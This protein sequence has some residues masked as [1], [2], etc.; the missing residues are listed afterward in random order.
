MTEQA[1]TSLNHL[2]DDARIWLYAANRELNE[3]EEN[4]VR[5]IL[6][7]FCRTWES[8]GRS[9]QSAADVLEGRFA[10]IAGCI[11]DGDVSGCGIDK[12]V[13]VLENAASE[14]AFEWLPGVLVH[15]RDD[16]GVPRSVTRQEFRKLVES[17]AINADT[18]VLDMSVQTLGQLRDGR[19]ERPAS[20][21]W[22]ARV[23]RIE[24]PTP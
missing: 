23:F 19:F 6:G 7:G 4:R 8:H 22:H 12:S 11:E 14:L 10:V 24:Q 5:E 1:T 17:D 2:P 20:E 13:H 3:L 16:R 15:Y 9:V 21:S 18:P